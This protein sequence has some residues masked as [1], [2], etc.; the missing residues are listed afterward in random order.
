MPP[1]DRAI[2]GAKQPRLRARPGRQHE[3]AR[4][5]TAVPVEEANGLAFGHP[6]PDA[7]DHPPDPARRL[8]RCPLEDR[9]LVDVVDHPQAVRGVDEEIRGVLDESRGPDEVTDRVD[10]ERRRLERRAVAV[11]LPAD[12]ADAPAGTDALAGEDV[13]DGPRTVTRL[14]PPGAAPG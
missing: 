12:D 8:R 9:E 3:V 2:T 6:G 5:R 14:A 7:L 13:R 4:Q 10:E 1:L 11:R